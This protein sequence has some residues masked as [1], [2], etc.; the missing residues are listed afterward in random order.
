MALYQGVWW[1][2]TD[3][4]SLHAGCSA[5]MRP[6]VGGVLPAFSQEG[7][8]AAAAPVLDGPRK[9]LKCA[10]PRLSASSVERGLWMLTDLRS[11]H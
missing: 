9:L 2:E 5:G 11:R 8:E 3:L 7:L 6:W 4:R 10:G 1:R